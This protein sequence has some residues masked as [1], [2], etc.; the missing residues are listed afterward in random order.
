MGVKAA[1]QARN[2]LGIK[3]L[4][5]YLPSYRLTYRPR[6]EAFSARRHF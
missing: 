4:G 3:G 6:T 5:Q 1:I 2:G